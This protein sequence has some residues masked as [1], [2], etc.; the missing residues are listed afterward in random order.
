[1]VSAVLVLTTVN[2]PYSTQLTASGG[3]TQTWT[4]VGGT[5]PAG[6]T[7]ATNGALSGTPTGAEVEFLRRLRFKGRQ[8]TPL[9]FYRELQNLRDPLHFAL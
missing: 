3:G 9:Y 6:L 2:A 8:P 5:P 1:M 4:V 7:L